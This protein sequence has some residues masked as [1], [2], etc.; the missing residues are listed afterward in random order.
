MQLNIIFC[1]LFLVDIDT[2]WY[3][4]TAKG[5]L[6]R[7]RGTI[8]QSKSLQSWLFMLNGHDHCVTKNEN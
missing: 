5:G 4:Y 2:H 1:W 8:Y 6:S 7:L 3:L